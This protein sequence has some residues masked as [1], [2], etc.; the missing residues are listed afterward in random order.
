MSFIEAKKVTVILGIIQ[1]MSRFTLVENG[2]WRRVFCQSFIFIL[3]TQY[4]KRETTNH[5]EVAH[6]S[7]AVRQLSPKSCCIGDCTQTALQINK[8]C[9]VV[10][11]NLNWR[12]EL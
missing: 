11:R 2:S 8:F 9:T 4:F 7:L 1:G 5:Q 6:G 3:N 12:F 10:R